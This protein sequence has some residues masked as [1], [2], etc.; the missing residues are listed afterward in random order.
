MA[1]LERKGLV[2]GVI[3]ED[4]DLIVFGCRK[5]LF[6][7]NPSTGAAQEYAYDRLPQ[8][9][10]MKNWDLARFRE[11]CILAGCDYLPNIPKIGLKTAF[12]LI[13]RYT[14]IDQVR[15]KL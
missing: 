7:L 14:D 2:D 10:D 12:K 13:Q 9:K 1:Y 5:I 6:K 11:V 8:L 3:T 4:S 15:N